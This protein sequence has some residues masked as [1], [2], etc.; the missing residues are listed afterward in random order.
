MVT[1]MINLTV[2]PTLGW[3]AFRGTDKFTVAV[4][5]VKAKGVVQMDL[6]SKSDPFAVVKLGE[7]TRRTATFQ[8]DHSPRFNETFKFGKLT[9]RDSPSWRLAP[10]DS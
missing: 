9:L 10:P 8:N 4:T 1:L 5:V 7:E 3:E 6:M 2:A